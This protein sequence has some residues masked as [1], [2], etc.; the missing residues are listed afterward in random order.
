MNKKIL[1]IQ[2]TIYDDSGKLLKKKKLYFVGLAHPLLSALLPEGWSIAE[3]KPEGWSANVTAITDGSNTIPLPNGFKVST[4][5]TEDEVTEGLV[6]TEG[7]NEFVWVPVTDSASYTED[8]FGPLTG[9]DTT[10]TDVYDSQEELDYYYGTDYYDYDDFT[11]ETDKTNVETSIQT[12]GGFYVGRYETG[13]M[14]EPKTSGNA[15]VEKPE[16]NVQV[17]EPTVEKAEQ[18]VENVQETVQQSEA[19]EIQSNTVQG[20]E[21]SMESVN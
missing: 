16:E 20:T 8:S 7:G 21:V 5:A 10:S 12:Y 6:I 4:K 3:T 18:S 9:T 11:Y 1:F 14:E 2:P 13:I 19:V 17:P 15:E